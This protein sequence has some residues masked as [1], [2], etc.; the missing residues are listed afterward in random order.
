MEVLILLRLRAPFVEFQRPAPPPS[1]N[2]SHTVREGNRTHFK[3]DIKCENSG[4]SFLR[5]GGPAQLPGIPRSHC[6]PQHE[7]M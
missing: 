7:L 3:R 5:L 1:P 2:E 6:S 4:S